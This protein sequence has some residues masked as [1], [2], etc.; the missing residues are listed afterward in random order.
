MGHNIRFRTLHDAAQYQADFAI[1]CRACG[2][3]VVVERLTLITIAQCWQL[4]TDRETLSA[5]LRCTACRKRG[6][7]LEYAP[8]GG[9]RTLR[10]EAGMLTPPRGVSISQWLKW[11]RDEQLE[12]LERL[13]RAEDARETQRRA[14]RAAPKW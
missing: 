11:S 9:V 2:R 7:R 14:S 10:L 4:S 8:P 3:E 13:R 1:I 5:R 6:C 12:Q